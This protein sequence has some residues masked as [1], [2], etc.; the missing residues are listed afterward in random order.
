MSE[1]KRRATDA[2]RRA[3]ATQEGPSEVKEQSE[4]FFEAVL[5]PDEE[6]A[7]PGLLRSGA[8]VA[9]AVAVSNLL[10]VVFQ[11][12]SAHLLTPAEYSL[13][14]TMFAILLVA[15]VPILSLQ[16]RVAREVAHALA[17]G[18]EEEAG[19]L[20]VET[21]R[22]LIRWGLIILAIGAMIAVPFAIIF[23]VDR[24]LPVIALAAAVMATVPLPI[25]WGG[26]QGS[27]RFMALGLSQLAYAVLKVVIGLGLAAVGFGA[28][29]I[30]FGLA[31]ATALTIVI[32]LLPLGAL[33]AVGR[34]HA[35]RRRKLLDS[36]TRGAAIV[37]VLIAALTN[38]DLLA[39]RAFLE[40]V[41]AGAYAAVSVAARGLLL[42][43]L[44][45][46]T[47]LFP[48]V[49]VL[50]N[51]AA[52]RDHLL[53]GLAAVVGLGLLPLIAFFV[54]PGPLIDVAF[55]SDYSAGKEWLG[56]LGLAMMIYALVEVYM[57]H[58]LALGRMA[59]GAVLGAGFVLQ[60]ALLAIFHEN[61]DQLIA[62]QIG[63]AGF[64]LVGSELFDRRDRWLNRSR[65]D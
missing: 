11:L 39:A 49:A 12:V 35:R 2:D 63:V 50:R 65:A 4:A 27:E 21:L 58:F 61:P 47:V 23:N 32:S 33:L 53:Y 34:K 10:N 3:P 37:L 6:G 16:A 43:P 45:A 30:V 17:G 9:I 22:P 14:V 1:V 26:L 51:L 19:G 36:Y 40:D 41:T 60:I 25:A 46:T 13:L 57:F 28:A 29:A 55:G 59:F 8:I 5:H 7:A 62:V 64:L 20:L 56:P 18:R 52:E 31:L 38:M 48:R 24:E 42:L 15:N 54:I 44:V